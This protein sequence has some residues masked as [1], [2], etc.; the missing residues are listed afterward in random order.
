[1]ILYIIFIVL[2]IVAAIFV[3][4]AIFVWGNDTLT[5]FSLGSGVLSAIILVA[6]VVLTLTSRGY[7][8]QNVLRMKIQEQIN[9][10]ESSRAVL[11]NKI[12]SETYT[13]LEV[14]SYN[15]SVKEYK[16][17]IQT[18]QNQYANPWI[19][20]LSSPVYNEFSI[21]AVSYLL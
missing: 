21:D 13:I 19:N 18:G 1:M 6:F 11:E 14:N 8:H 20:W 17:M 2:F 15:E 10:I 16:I 9:S 12:E 3:S 5:V 7:Y 4:L